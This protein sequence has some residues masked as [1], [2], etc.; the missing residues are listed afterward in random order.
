MGASGS[1]LCPIASVNCYPLLEDAVWFLLKQHFQT[2]PAT[3]PHADRVYGAVDV[4]RGGWDL[5][6][7]V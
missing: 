5:V 4:L 6:V 3:P 1:A 7:R 2:I